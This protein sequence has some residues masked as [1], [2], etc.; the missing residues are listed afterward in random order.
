MQ[1]ELPRCAEAPF[2]FMENL[3]V[4]EK[5]NGLLL[6]LGGL[7][8]FDKAQ[9]HCTQ[10]TAHS[11]RHAVQRSVIHHREYEDAAVGC[12]QCA[13]EGHG[14]RTGDRRTYNAA[15]QN[16]QRVGCCASSSSIFSFVAS[17]RLKAVALPQAV[18]R[19]SAC[20]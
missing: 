9:D 13:A 14:Q 7:G 10:H 17:P 2:A 3:S 1:K 12:A 8:L 16:A 19:R 18:P 15:G 6:C 4:M 5:E 20:A 11:Q